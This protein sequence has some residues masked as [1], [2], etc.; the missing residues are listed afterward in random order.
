MDSRDFDEFLN[1]RDVPDVPSNLSHRIIEAAKVMPQN[2]K[3]PKLGRFDWFKDLMPNVM[4]PQPAFALG[5][6]LFLAIGLGLFSQGIIVTETSYQEP[7]D[8]SLAFYV[9]DLMGAEDLL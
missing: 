3:L 4:S 6:F 2:S 1:L 7:S 9:D 5:V 8:V